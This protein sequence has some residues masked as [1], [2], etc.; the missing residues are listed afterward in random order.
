MK[1]A[2]AAAALLSLVSCGES[3]APRQAPRGE[4][5]ECAIGAAAWQRNCTLEYVERQ[6]GLTLVVHN[7]QGGFRRLLVPRDGSGAIAADG[8]EPA[9]VTVI[10]DGRAEVT[11]GRDR[12]RL[13]ATI[14]PA[15]RPA[16]R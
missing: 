5:I 4:A 3:E 9:S 6:D 14:G 2:F 15:P 7:A 8:A 13:P 10:G 16:P 12:Y 11:V 1:I